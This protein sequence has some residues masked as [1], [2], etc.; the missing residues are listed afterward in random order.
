MV[1]T[2]FESSLGLSNTVGARAGVPAGASAFAAITPARLADTRANATVVGYTRVDADT[3]R[4]QIAGRQ[5]VP[6]DAVAAVLNITVTNTRSAGYVT[7][8]PAGSPRPN[9]SNVNVDYVG[10]TI[11]NLATV[12]LGVGGAVDI[13]VQAQADILVDIT[14][15]YTPVTNAVA[16]GRFVALA[17][18][19][20]VL[21][22]RQRGTKVAAM[23]IER[24]DVSMAVPLHATAVVLNLTVVDSSGGGHWTAY[25]M[26][27][28]MTDSSNLNADAPGQTRANQAIIPLGAVGSRRGFDIFS[29]AGGHLLVDVAGYFTNASAPWTTEGLFVP[30]APQ[31]Q[32]DTRS[33]G[34]YGR[35]FAGWTTEFDFDGRASAQAVVVNLTATQTRG[36]GH[37]TAYPARTNR[38]EVSNLNASFINQT[39]AN[40][41]IVTTSTIGVAIFSAGGG[42]VIADV[43]GYFTGSPIS[44]YL[45]RPLNVVPPPYVGP[46]LPYVLTIPRLGITVN[47]VEGVS[48]AVV[49]AGNVGHWSGTGLAGEESPIVLFGHRTSHGGVFRS[50]HLL[51]AGDEYT[52]TSLD[53]RV[54]RYRYVQRQITSASA[55]SIFAAAAAS[56][57]PSLSLV[58]C[59]KSNFLP[60]SLAYR[61]VVSG[62]QIS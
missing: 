57:T 16:A 61:I 42:H 40:H 4:V 13:F 58:A 3:I 20:R 59:S 29:A 21:D 43:A 5:A 56:P 47:V 35:L 52:L 55:L 22:T 6:D 9:A 34:S 24:V 31:R 46:D 17:E 49:N 45:D 33:P 18:A 53:G 2:L 51:Q 39:I 12:Q 62:V 37:Y 25:T 19:Q 54:F 48:D 44:A 8:Y 14:G 41:A 11:P 28:P 1:T 27:A 15:A 60:T 50:L 38:P 7:V 10:Q 26:G 23:A 32:L 30:S 36:G